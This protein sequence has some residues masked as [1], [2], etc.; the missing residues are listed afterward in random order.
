VSDLSDFLVS[1]TYPKAFALVRDSFAQQPDGQT[2]GAAAVRHGLLL[3]GLLTPVHLLESLLEIRENEGTHYTTLLGCLQRLGFEARHVTKPRKQRTAAFLD[4]LRP[5]LERDGAFLLPCLYG[6]DHWVCLGAWDG[7]RA[8]VVDSFYGK[9]WSWAPRGL[10]PN[11][12]A[13]P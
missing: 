9:T 11:S 12:T 3:G 5:E 8:W 7:E 4:E 13:L 6:G 2:C 1:Q 10:R